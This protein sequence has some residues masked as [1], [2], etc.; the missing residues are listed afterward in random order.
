M[1]EEGRKI[2]VRLSTLEG[3]SKV[4]K[5]VRDVDEEFVR[6]AKNEYKYPKLEFEDGL[7][8]NLYTNTHNWLAYYWKYID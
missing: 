5:F 8:Y 4:G 6:L 7:R 1:P 3:E 2:E